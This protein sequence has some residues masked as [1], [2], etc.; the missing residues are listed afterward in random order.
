[1]PDV[2]RVL[3]CSIDGLRPDALALTPTP[4]ID[5]LRARGLTCLTARSVMP[6]VTL[7]CHTS[8]FLGVPPERHGVV[9]N[10]WVPQ[11]RPIQSLTEVL[12][13][14]GHSTAAWYNWEEL[15]DLSRP[16]CLDLSYM[17]KDCYGASSDLLLADRVVPLIREQPTDFTFLYLGHVDAAGH[18]HGWMS[19]PYLAAVTRAD[20]ALGRVLAALPADGLAVLVTADHGGHDRTH[21]TASDDDL[22][23]P[24]VLSVPGGPTGELP[25]A[26][27]LDVAPTCAAL[28]GVAG[29]PE[30]EGTARG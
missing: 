11:V 23:L 19:E 14:A 21:G 13:R 16:G 8:M 17:Q 18:D 3:L 9:T 22:L 1:M 28:L 15:R 12:K 4:V 10:T 6:S 20:E 24:F 26:S 27:I 30:W 5:D 29:A 2:K 7:P 25:E